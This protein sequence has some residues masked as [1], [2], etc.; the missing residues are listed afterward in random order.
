MIEKAAETGDE[1][2]LTLAYALFRRKPVRKAAP[3][4]RPMTPELADE[5]RAY[6][7]K[8]PRATLGRIAQVFDTNPG[9]VSEA[10]GGK[11]T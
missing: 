2:L 7:A 5:I 8:H 4:S 6:A 9:R 11:R 1:E 10:L 3:Q